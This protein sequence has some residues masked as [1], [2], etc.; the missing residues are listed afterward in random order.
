[1]GGAAEVVVAGAAVVE[2]ASSELD[3]PEQLAASTNRAKR[4]E[5][6]VAFSS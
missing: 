3:S 5:S 1:V 4:M 6:F 2:V